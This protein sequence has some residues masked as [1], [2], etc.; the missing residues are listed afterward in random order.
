VLQEVKAAGY[1]GA[2]MLSHRPNYSGEDIYRLR[3][4]DAGYLTRSH[5]YDEGIMMGEFSGINAFM[6]SLL[7]TEQMAD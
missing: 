1:R 2:L 6:R 3:R 7:V 5:C 4:V